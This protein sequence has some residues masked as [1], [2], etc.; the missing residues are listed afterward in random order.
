MMADR[1]ALRSPRVLRLAPAPTMM[2]SFA[3]RFLPLQYRGMCRI[4]TPLCL[5][6]HLRFPNLPGRRP[7]HDAQPREPILLRGVF[8]RLRFGLAHLGCLVQRWHYLHCTHTP[9]N[10]SA[11]PAGGRSEVFGCLYRYECLLGAL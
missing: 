5:L 7:V 4:C 10:G 2:L 1:S 3:W 6:L 8:G 9:G 11:K